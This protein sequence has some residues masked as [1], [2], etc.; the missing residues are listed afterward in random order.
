MAAKEKQG[1]ITIDGNE[2]EVAKLSDT[3]KAQIMNVRSTDQEIE[4]LRRLLAIAQTA[5]LAYAR[6]LSEELKTASAQ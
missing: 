1:I 4:R 6:A 3:A 5:R 2:Y